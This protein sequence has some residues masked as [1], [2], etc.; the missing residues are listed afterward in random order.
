MEILAMDVA[1]SVAWIAARRPGYVG[2]VL[3]VDLAT[4][5]V[6]VEHPVSLPAGVRIDDERTWVTSYET[7]ELLGFP[8]VGQRPQTSPAGG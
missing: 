1:D 7:N 3:A 5:D 2:T 8:R 4:G 6:L